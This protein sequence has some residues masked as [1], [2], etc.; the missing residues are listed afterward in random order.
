LN[1]PPSAVD[2]PLQQH[3]TTAEPDPAPSHGRAGLLRS[4]TFRLVLIYVLLFSISVGVLL[5]FIYWS[6]AA[7]MEQQ[8]DDTIRAE[9][10]G[11]AERYQIASL[12]GL[13]NSI[14]ERLKRN[15]FGSTIYLLTNPEYRRISGNLNGWPSVTAN[16][17]GWIEFPLEQIGAPNQKHHARAR[18]F[19]LESGFHLLVGRDMYELRATQALI[20]RTLITGVLIT[21]LL[22][23]GGGIM[24]TH[25][26][27]RRIEA[28][29]A[30]S[31]DIMRGD[32]SQRIPTHGTSDDFDQLAENL[33]NMLD[34]IQL[35]MEGVRH[36]S[37]NIAHDLKTPLTRLR[38]RLE[39]LS[40]ESGQ[41]NEALFEQSQQA[42]AEADAMLSTFNALL[43]IAR[44]E[45]GARRAAFS[46]VDL[47][48][49]VNDVV[50]LYEPLAEEKSQ[51][52]ELHLDTVRPIQ[53]D[54]DLLFQAMANLLDN[55]IKYS[56]SNANIIVTL[57][58]DITGC[59]IEVRDSGP[60][61]QPQDHE[62]VLQRFVRLE[63]SRST[64][65]NGLGLS[66]VAAVAK[67]HGA[68]IRMEDAAPGNI[69]RLEFPATRL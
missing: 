19:V 65:G 51:K 2:T 64:P 68:L 7:Y 36:V 3:A 32:L 41:H 8:I 47:S 12:N 54:R 45:A 22:A 27:V 25:S 69:A 6:T 5:G 39:S 20:K 60:G 35:L 34:Q 28:I 23:L 24:M 46:S 57:R 1:S 21:A 62:R 4:A 49:V 31:R 11:L 13:V 42:L 56:P 30:T 59:S 17:D 50:E 33:N 10:T 44:I 48:A 67:L 43:R 16:S 26:T 18:S 40:I 37:D 52:L 55:A 61:I 38:N 58:G 14:D 9:I 53:G 29:N 63:S 15:P 66:L